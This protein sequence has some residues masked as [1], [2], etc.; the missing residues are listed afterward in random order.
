VVE[1]Q[2]ICRTHKVEITTQEEDMRHMGPECIVQ[3]Q[4]QGGLGEVEAMTSAPA[5]F[6]EPMN[7]GEQVVHPYDTKEEQEARRKASV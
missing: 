6:S 2:K 5:F 7:Y 1:L 4:G 3:E